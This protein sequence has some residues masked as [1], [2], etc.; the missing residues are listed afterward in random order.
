MEIVQIVAYPPTFRGGHS[1]YT[2]KLA[3][4]LFKDYGVFTRFIVPFPVYQNCHI[5]PTSD[6]FPIDI[7]PQEN[8]ESFLSL[9]PENVNTIIWHFAQL[10]GGGFS[11][12]YWLTKILR[13]AVKLRRFN[14]VVMFHELSLTLSFKNKIKLFYPLRFFAAR[15]IAKI[16]NHIVTFSV[17][18]EAILGKWVKTPITAIPAFSTIGEP[19]DVTSL[20]KR[21]SR[22]IVFGAEYSRE[23]VYKKYLKELLLSCQL[24]KIEEICDVGAPTGLKL[25]ELPG[26]RI[27]EMGEPP[28]EV[29][30]QL[31]LNSYAGFFDYSHCPK[32]TGKSTIV[33]A[34]SAHGLIPV[35]TTDKIEA[36]GLEYNKN[37]V[38]ADENLK[39]FNSIELQF[40]AD[41]ARQWY[42]NHS[43]KEHAKVFA[44]CLNIDN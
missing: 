19:S 17:G 7:L 28:A 27:V 43:L 8:L 9:I 6:G 10:E 14:L 4:Q 34:Y 44:S 35:S 37:Y 15:G 20:E 38:V 31:M 25:P 26:I 23:R 18:H 2:L 11:N 41:N 40:I 42:H 32:D 24:L 39:N 13:S 3:E 21:K 29:V 30:S 22:M 16:A 12:L 1:T 36:T 33:G 5:S